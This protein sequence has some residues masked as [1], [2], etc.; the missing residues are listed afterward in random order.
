MASVCGLL[1]I[2]SLN[3]STHENVRC[4]LQYAGAARYAGTRGVLGRIRRLCA[5]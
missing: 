3:E 1:N 5:L 4:K 2:Q